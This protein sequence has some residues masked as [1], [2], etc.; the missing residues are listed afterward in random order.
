MTVANTKAGTPIV[1]FTVDEWQTYLDAEIR[2]ATD[3]E[4]VDA[5]VAAFKAGEI[6]DADPE[7]AALISL[8]WIGQNGDSG[9]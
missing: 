7:V 5:F 3:M 4:S 2:R 8:L 1:D 9:A 6:D